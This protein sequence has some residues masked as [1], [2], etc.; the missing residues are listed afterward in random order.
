MGKSGDTVSVRPSRDEDMARIT[1]IYAGAVLHGLASFEYEP[2]A[3]HEMS[4][5]REALLKDGYPYLVAEVA[6][7][8]AGYAYAGA[9]R[10]RAGY[11]NTVEDAIY[12]DPAFHRKGV[13]QALLAK[14][15]EECEARDFRLMV[16]V[17]GD[18]ANTGSIEL[19]RAAGFRLVGTFHSIGYKHGQWLDSVQMERKLGPGDSMPPDRMGPA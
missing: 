8:V 18:S 5:R 19:H 13:G 12:V 17:I 4:H 11:F 3:Q 9:Y 14:L 6:G 1:E 16:A 7:R 2:P 15:I 10:T